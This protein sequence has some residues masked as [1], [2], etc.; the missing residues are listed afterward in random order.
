MDD[1]TKIWADI[2]CLGQIRG[3]SKGVCR[4]KIERRLSHFTPSARNTV[5]ALEE[6]KK[7]FEVHDR[8]LWMETVEDMA[9]W[10]RAALKRCC[11]RSKEAEARL[12]AFNHWLSK[13][14]NAQ[15]KDSNWIIVIESEIARRVGARPVSEH[16]RSAF[17]I[18]LASFA[19][20][21][22]LKPIKFIFGGIYAGKSF[23][24]TREYPERKNP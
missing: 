13:M 23:F 11:E 21:V 2:F 22:D 7:L 9:K 10:R 4:K 17:R 19:M 14:D 18:N 6:A 1:K 15:E 5:G 24:S 12:L 20:D 3:Y 16:S 8:F